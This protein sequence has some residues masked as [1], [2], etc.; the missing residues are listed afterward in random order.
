[1]N[2][3]KLQSVPSLPDFKLPAPY[4]ADFWDFKN[5]D[6]YNN[7][8]NAHKDDWNRRGNSNNT[9]IDFCICKNQFIRE[10]IKYFMYSLIQVSKNN[11][12]TFA[13][14]FEKTRVIIRFSNEKLTGFYSLTELTDFSLFEDYIT[15]EEKIPKKLEHHGLSP[16]NSKLERKPQIK[17]SPFVR[18]LNR[19]ISLLNDFYDDRPML[20]KDIWQV[21]Q[22]PYNVRVNKISPIKSINFSEI[23]QSKIKEAAKEYAKLRLN[24]ITIESVC[25]AI[26]SIKM[27]SLWLSEKHPEI[28][29][30]F[31]INRN[32]M[33]EYIKWAKVQSGW[34]SKVFA[35]HLGNLCTVFDYLRLTR[36]DYV[37]NTVV[38]CKNDYKV[39]IKSELK[40]YSDEEMK[41]INM[42][43]NYLEDIQD[44]RL[45]YL[46]QATGCR[47]S[48]IMLLTP[49]Q[50]II[51][52]GVYQLKVIRGKNNK[53]HRIPIEKMTA[54][55]ILQAY[56]ES[57]HRYGDN[58]V[59]VFAKSENEN[60]LR[61]ELQ[62]HL[63]QLAYDY[64]LKDDAGRPLN[65]LLKRF[66]TTIS[67]KLLEEG[68]DANIISLLLGHKVKGTLKHYAAVSNPKLKEAMQP[69]LDKYELLINSIGK[70]ENVVISKI[71][72]S[73]QIPLPNGFC[74]KNPV[75]GI[76]EHAN[77]CLS[78]SMFCPDPRYLLGYKLQLAEV[79][80]A[81][82]D[83]E[84]KGNERLLEIHQKT[85][86]ELISIIEKMEGTSNE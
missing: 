30:L 44:A 46:L 85:R 57:K 59:Y 31:Q 60:M 74:S 15:N 84:E 3:L 26:L 55:V 38:I 42:H 54:D 80:R 17:K 75:T 13:N 40:P 23:V 25:N 78:C 63:R 68:L 51:N 20:E 10:E 83:A 86:T 47:L 48:E 76:C 4:N 21:D 36:K 70:I 41:T 79:E 29:S 69:R 37:P 77:S 58:V 11:L 1:M 27:I 56:E 64:K 19:I 61:G 34:S 65:I 45:V 50:L 5:W 8:S 6:Y 32:I 2:A 62:N 82:T 33:E 53:V 28:D 71:N 12:G 72:H 49:D 43:L 7:S 14:T 9:G 73:E 16:I 39:K 52:N 81:I 66:R 24:S 18:L 22:L 67:C 35:K